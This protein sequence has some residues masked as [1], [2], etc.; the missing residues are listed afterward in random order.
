MRFT[1]KLP[2][3]LPS[4]IYYKDVARRREQPKAKIKYSVKT[5]VHTL[6][7][8]DKMKNKQVLI[9]R[10][11]PV[12]FKQSE[13]QMEKAHIKVCCCCSKGHS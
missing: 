9:I 5:V 12:D 13:Q 2:D 7:P 10:S 11:K 3:E 1:F 6:D 8:N 4:S